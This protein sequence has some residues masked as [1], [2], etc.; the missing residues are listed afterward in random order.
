MCKEGLPIEGFCVAAG[1]PTTEKA[2][3]I[4]DGLKTAG[5]RHVVFKPKS[6]DGIC[7]VVNITAA[8]PDF[9]I[10]LQWTG[11]AGGHHSFEDFYQPILATYRRS[12]ILVSA[13]QMM[14]GSI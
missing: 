14:Y 9:P 5:I 8:N 7:Q 1:V 13:L 6:V 4:I 12:P 10:I 3:K 11:R 2:V